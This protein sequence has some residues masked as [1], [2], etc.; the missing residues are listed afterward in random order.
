MY[1]KILHATDL[2]ENH[3]ELCQQVVTLAH[4]LGAELHFLHV[5]ETPLSLQWAQSLGF[6]E[7]ARPVKED[8]QTVM[9]TLGE[10][11]NIP[12]SHLHVEVGSA[13]MGILETIK[14]LGSDLL[15]L[16]SHSAKALPSFPGSTAHAVAHHA[17]CDILTM[18][19]AD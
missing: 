13:Y 10:A 7:L 3:F 12:A 18:R 14:A 16:G 8:A 17:P 5:V 1:K 15:I 2:R 19:S 9:T 4:S 11:L 6:A